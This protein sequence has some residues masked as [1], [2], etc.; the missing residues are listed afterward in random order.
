MVVTFGGQVEERRQVFPHDAVQDGVLRGAR[1]VEVDGR[2]RGRKPR[3][4]VILERRRPRACTSTVT[5]RFPLGPLSFLRAYADFPQR[6]EVGLKS[7][8]R[9]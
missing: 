8:S 2:R 4:G 6:F 9:K 7:F 1:T 5:R 3:I